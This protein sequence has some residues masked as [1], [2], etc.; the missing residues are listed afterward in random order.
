MV[1]PI[2]AFPVSDGV[3]LRSL[4][5]SLHK[6]VSVFLYSRYNLARAAL[7]G[8]P[9]YCGMLDAVLGVCAPFPFGDL[10]RMWN[11]IVSILEHS[12]FIYFVSAERFTYAFI[13]TSS[14]FS[15]I[16]YVCWAK[17]LTDHPEIC[18]NCFVVKYFETNFWTL[19]ENPIWHRSCASAETWHSSCNLRMRIHIKPL[20]CTS[21]SRTDLSLYSYHRSKQQ[22]FCA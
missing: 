16:C 6:T 12:I 5:E 13:R 17:V 22:R 9:L 4:T 2:T 20:K 18:D 8:F 19:N 11:S 10:A 3:A 14:I 7:S 15:V 21:S 1:S